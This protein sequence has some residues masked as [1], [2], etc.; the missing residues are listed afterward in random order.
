[1]WDGPSLVVGRPAHCGLTQPSTSSRACVGSTPPGVLRISE[2]GTPSQASPLCLPGR[3]SVN[4][5][6][7]RRHQA[8]PLFSESV[9]LCCHPDPTGGEGPASHWGLSSAC[10]PA[11]VNDSQDEAYVSDHSRRGA[12]SREDRQVEV[13]RNPDGRRQDEGPKFRR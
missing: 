3:C 13:E 12:K 9:L 10:A 11:P 1:V 8:A 6:P 7:S 4:E 2:R 5:T